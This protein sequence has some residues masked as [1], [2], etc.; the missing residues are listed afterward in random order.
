[1]LWGL[2]SSIA[3]EVP[4]ILVIREILN[5]SQKDTV[6]V[7]LLGRSAGLR[8][9]WRSFACKEVLDLT[10][11]ERGNAVIEFDLVKVVVSFEVLGLL[12]AMIY[13]LEAAEDDRGS[14]RANRH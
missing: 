4:S 11:D 1:M 2:L 6:P 3:C 7:E 9:R 8:T 5:L 14:K 13:S 10:R 12:Y